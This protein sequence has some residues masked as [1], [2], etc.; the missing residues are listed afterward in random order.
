MSREDLGRVGGRRE[1]EHDQ[2]TRCDILEELL[3]YYLKQ[4]K[5][6]RVIYKN[7]SEKW[8]ERG[9]FLSTIL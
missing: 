5:D 3:K 1:G 8:R 2:Q 9:P 7:S 6:F 4:T